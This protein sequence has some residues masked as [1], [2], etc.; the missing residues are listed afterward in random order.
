[1]AVVFSLDAGSAIDSAQCA[2]PVTPSTINLLVYGVERRVQVPGTPT[3]RRRERIKFGVRSSGSTR[4]YAHTRLGRRGTPPR[5]GQGT[6]GT[7][8]GC[9]ATISTATSSAPWRHAMTPTTNP[10]SRAGIFQ[11]KAT[12]SGKAAMV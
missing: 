5:S 7:S 11:A 3:C 12:N 10:V 9:T 6:S 1:M 8:T 2:V 4:A